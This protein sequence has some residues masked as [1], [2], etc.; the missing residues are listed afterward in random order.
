MSE[1][2]ACPLCGGRLKISKTKN[3]VRNVIKVY[4]KC[5]KCGFEKTYEQPPEVTLEDWLKQ[6]LDAEKIGKGVG[7]TL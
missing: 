2:S 5:S 6:A 3:P 7:S 1:I 4:V